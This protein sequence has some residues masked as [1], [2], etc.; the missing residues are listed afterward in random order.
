MISFQRLNLN[1][2]FVFE[3]RELHVLDMFK[4]GDLFFKLLDFIK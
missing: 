2:M 4:I 1:M 3:F